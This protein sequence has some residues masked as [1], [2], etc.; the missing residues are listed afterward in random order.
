MQFRLLTTALVIRRTVWELHNTLIAHTNTLT[1]VVT[2]VT[3]FRRNTGIGMTVDMNRALATGLQTVNQWMAGLRLINALVATL[4]E[5]IVGIGHMAGGTTGTAIVT[6]FFTTI[7]AHVTA[8]TL[9]TGVSDTGLVRMLHHII[10]AYFRNL[11]DFG[12]NL[13]RMRLRIRRHVL[14]VGFAT[15]SRYD[16]VRIFQRVVTIGGLHIVLKTP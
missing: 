10:R 6:A 13:I 16:T 7:H 2:G 11:F 3:G 12:C 8:L 9:L 14:F 1:A 15:H 5:T 4:I